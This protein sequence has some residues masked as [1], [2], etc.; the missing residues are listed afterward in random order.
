MTLHASLPA[1]LLR[2]AQLQQQPVDRHAIVEASEKSA[3]HAHDPAILL[4]TLAQHLHWKTPQRVRSADPAKTPLLGHHPQRGWILIRG[5]DA[6]DQWLI[7]VWDDTALKFQEQ[8]LA[9]LDECF[10]AKVSLRSPFESSQSPVYQLVK[11]ELASQKRAVFE[12]SLGGIVLNCVALG[13]SLYSMQVYDRVVP[14]GAFQTLWVLTLG[15]LLAILFEWAIKHVRSHLFSDLIDAIDQR[16]ARAVYVR[17][18]AIRLDQMPRSVGGLA[19][20][21]RG[22]E[23]VRGFMTAIT[24]QM[25]IDAPFAILFLALIGIMGHPF[26]ALVPAIFLLISLIIGTYFRKKIETLALKSTSAANFKTGLLVET[27]E[28][29][30]TIKA[31]QGGWRMLGKWLSVTDE[32]RQNELEM[33]EITERNQ[34]LTA[35]FQQVSYVLMVATGALMVSRGELTMG[36]LIACSILSGRVLTPFSMVPAQ[37]VQ[38]AQVKA[39]LQSLDQIWRLQDDHHGIDH[40][41]A[42]E[43]IQGHYQVEGVATSYGGPQQALVIPKLS[44]QP[45]E[46]IGVI[47]PIGSGKTTLL[48]LLSG[49]YRPSQ[50]RIL[51]DQIDMGHLSKPLLANHIGF[52]QQDGRLFAGS[53]RENLILGQLDPGDEAILEAAQ[54]TGL[55]QTV[56]TPHPKGLMQDIA[57]GGT[58]LSAGQRQLVNL[59]RIYLR[60]PTIWLLDEPTSSMDRQTEMAVLAMLTECIQPHHTLVLVTH[61]PEL[62]A[63]VDRLMVIAKNQIV[64]DGPKAQVVAQLQNKPPASQGVNA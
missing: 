9:T 8:T 51:L 30:E 38:W 11:R 59:T 39:A 14:T 1:C 10:M 3:A 17:F 48:R 35:S 12:A 37:L 4:R 55:L 21:L 63:L 25:L 60:R 32:A 27:V 53:L 58:G 42:P 40:P 26:L 31:G 18:L 7:E 64:M 15:V 46:K 24:T 5:Q 57:E 6:R 44:I 16:L 43:S 33:R 41:I 47:G 45:G 13:T 56:I 28:G 49:M 22:Y 20:Q 50:G 54:K 2:L 62:L 34:H 36:A 23:T 61:K 29:A 19:S 52:L